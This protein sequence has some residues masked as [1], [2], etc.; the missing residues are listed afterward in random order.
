MFEDRTMFPCIFSV[1][2]KGVHRVYEENNNKSKYLATILSSDFVIG[3]CDSAHQPTTFHI[4]MPS[5]RV[6]F[7]PNSVGSVS[8]QLSFFFFLLSTQRRQ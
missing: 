4:G 2:E 3:K 1:H 7:T 6:V 8:N 5:I